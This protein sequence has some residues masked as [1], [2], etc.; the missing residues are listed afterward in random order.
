[1]HRLRPAKIC[2]MKNTE[3]KRILVY[4]FCP[5]KPEIQAQVETDSLLAEACGKGT[6]FSRINEADIRVTLDR[7][8]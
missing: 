8:I 5:L 7:E 4:K 6:R 1:M 3:K 2:M